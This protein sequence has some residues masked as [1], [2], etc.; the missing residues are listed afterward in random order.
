MKSRTRPEE[1]I[2]IKRLS[3]VGKESVYYFHKENHLTP[4]QMGRVIRKYVKAGIIT[5]D[6]NSIQLTERG[7]AYIVNN[8]KRLFLMPK[9]RFWANEIHRYKE[10]HDVTVDL[11]LELYNLLEEGF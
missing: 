8:R 4:A 1:T 2:V 5:Q 6:E 9:K 11:V 7:K 10:S 3:L